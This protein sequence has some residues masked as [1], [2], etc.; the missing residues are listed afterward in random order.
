MA[1]CDKCGDEMERR[2]RGPTKEEQ[3]R[4]ALN[5][6]MI[7]APE[8]FCRSKH[9]KFYEVQ[10]VLAYN[11]E[12][13]EWGVYALSKLREVPAYVVP[14]RGMTRAERRATFTTFYANWSK[15][16]TLRIFC[17]LEP[18]TCKFGVTW[19]APIDNLIWNYI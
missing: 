19:S 13:K 2:G 14:H 5:K 1:H 3:A 7:W 16:V 8:K 10:H 15:D 9:S 4:E 12:T 17:R 18:G 11:T 6:A